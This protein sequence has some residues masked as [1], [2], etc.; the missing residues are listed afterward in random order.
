MFKTLNDLDVVG[1]TA[2]VRVDLNVPMQDGVVGDVTRIER[3]HATVDA[4]SKAGAKVVLLSHFGRPKGRVVPEMSLAPI[5]EVVAAVLNRPVVFAESCVGEKARA[6]IAHATEGALILLENLRF[7]DGEEANDG[8]FADAL[9]ALGDVYVNDAFSA[10]HRAHASTEALA[11]RLPAAVG[12][13]MEAELNALN[14]ALG[15]PVRPLAAIVGGAKIST[16]LAVLE[17]LVDRVDLL[18]VGGGMANTFLH[19]MGKDVAKSLCEP[20][21]AATAMKILA[22]AD[23]VGC[24]IGLPSDVT[25]ASEFKAGAACRTV[26]V[27]AVRADEMILDIGPESVAALEAALAGCKTLIWNGPMGAFETPPFD[28]GTV[29]LAKKAAEMTAAGALTSVAGGGDTVAALAAAGVGDRFTY[30][31]TAG[32]A[33]L[34]WM[35]GRTLPG[36]AALSQI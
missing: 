31:S 29:K 33:F 1:K 17:H 28:V 8:D 13:N 27:D 24:R 10:A 18:I 14:A 2:L 21:L 23:A 7:H 4:L 34:E 11:K 22:R 16:K 9:A 30:I 3:I 20:D 32:G 25:V 15:A 26:P 6:A 36:V 35:E 19:A 12:R 5:A